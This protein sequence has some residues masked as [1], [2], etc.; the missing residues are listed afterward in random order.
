MGIELF[1]TDCEKLTSK[2]FKVDFL[3]FIMICSIISPLLMV[4]D[5][6]T[7]QKIYS[8]QI[9]ENQPAWNGN[10][11]H[12]ELT[13]LSNI[14]YIGAGDEKII[15][16]FSGWDYSIVNNGSWSSHSINP[17]GSLPTNY[18][19]SGGNTAYVSS[20][21]PDGTGA[22]S[23]YNGM[24]G[25]DSPG[26]SYLTTH[27]VNTTSTSVSSQTGNSISRYGDST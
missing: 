13:N 8:T 7:N 6:L 21:G 19:F 10:N 16:F 23:N 26:E 14:D 1:I 20:D 11:W 4:H 12:T 5:E 3:I 24:Y 17:T 18:Y 15:T 25:A 22:P 9:I 2:I 27:V